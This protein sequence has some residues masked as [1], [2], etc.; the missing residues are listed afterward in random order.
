MA[1]D[2]PEVNVGTDNDV[3][4]DFGVIMTFHIGLSFLYAVDDDPK[5]SLSS[6][7]AIIS[8]K[9]SNNLSY[10]KMLEQMFR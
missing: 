10:R 8:T 6:I 1:G 4:K 7:P 5:F 3:F 2:S 9:D